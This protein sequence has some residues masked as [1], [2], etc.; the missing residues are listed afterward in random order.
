MSTLS[1][2]IIQLAHARDLP[3]PGYAT[4][5]SAGMDLTAALPADAPLTLAPGQRGAIPTGLSIALPLSHEAQIRPR[6]GFALKHGLTVLN[7][8]GTIDSDYRGEIV[9]LL[10][11]LG[12]EPF[13]IARGD[14]IAQMV[15]APVTQ[16]ALAR[17]NALPDTARGAYGFGSTGSAGEAS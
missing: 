5:G 17:V 14:R 16:V 8:P 12:V 1:V 2:P 10:I 9:V 6:S 4:A 7:S 3:L 11:N 15:I 13:R